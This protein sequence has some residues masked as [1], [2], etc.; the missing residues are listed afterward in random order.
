M[1]VVGVI[2]YRNHS[3]KIVNLLLKNKK[4]NKIL[5]YCYKEKAFQKKL[6]EKKNK[7]IFY[8]NN[9]DFLKES[10]FFFITSPSTTH[11]SYIKK[12]LRHK[13]PIFCE[14]PGFSSMSEYNYLN[15]LSPTDK[16]R[17]FFNYN[18]LHSKLY[19]LVK[20]EIL[21]NK[22][23]NIS[24]HSCIGISFLRKFKNN[25]RFTT[26]NILERISGNLGV[27][28]IN[29]SIN[30]LGSLK[31]FM[32]KESCVSNKKK[33]DTCNL[34]LNFCNGSS[35]TIFLSYAAPMTDRV[36]FYFSNKI[37]VCENNAIYSIG[38]RDTFDKFG[39]FKR[40][41]KKKIHKFLVNL[42]QDSL[43]DSLNFFIETVL[44]KR[45]FQKAYFDNALT[46]GKL[47]LKKI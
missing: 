5:V 28:Y 25:W 12:L 44:K 18:L 39:L 43:L 9:L 29:F 32:I 34:N 31:N 40:P 47:F 7:K 38:P 36:E 22:L 16:K 2:G 8:I 6:L 19:Q 33:I 45:N 10:S 3:L 26:N 24:V 46:T 35:A 27:H 20:K 13:K 14:K 17:I 15:K 4:I 42:S 11:H 1:L 37:I 41:P 21:K 30:L 23:I